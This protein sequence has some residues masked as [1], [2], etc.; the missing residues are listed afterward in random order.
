MDMKAMNKKIPARPFPNIS[1]AA[2]G[3]LQLLGKEARR[4]GASFF[5]PDRFC[6][7]SQRLRRNFKNS[8]L[9]PQTV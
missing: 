3:I 6:G 8:A 9:R 7:F 5:A 1:G 2:I 4:A